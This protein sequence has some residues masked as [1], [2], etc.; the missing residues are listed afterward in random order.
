MSYISIP[1]SYFQ[2]LVVGTKLDIPDSKKP[3][4][5][6]MYDTVQKMGIDSIFVV[7]P[8]MLNHNTRPNRA[9]EQ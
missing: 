1:D 8:H 9:T 7:S 4:Y 6:S 2:V 5:Y 3:F